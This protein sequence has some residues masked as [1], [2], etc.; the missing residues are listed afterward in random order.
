MK[1]K[2]RGKKATKFAVVPRFSRI[3]FFFSAAP[4]RQE[5]K[6][7]REWVCFTFLS[8]WGWLYCNF[9]LDHPGLDILSSQIRDLLHSQMG[10]IILD[11]FQRHND[12]LQL[13]I[14]TTDPKVQRKELSI[15]LKWRSP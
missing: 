13:H 2:L 8:F 11:G 12:L 1:Q 15:D 10:M 5:S 9:I 6:I 14:G 3:V 4:K 7:L